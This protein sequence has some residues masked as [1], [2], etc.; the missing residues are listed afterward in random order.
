MFLKGIIDHVERL[1]IKR[2]QVITKRPFIT[3]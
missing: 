1:N 2:A 3:S